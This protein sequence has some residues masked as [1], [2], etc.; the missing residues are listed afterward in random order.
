MQENIF[1]KIRIAEERDFEFLRRNDRHVT[2]EILKKKIADKNI[3]IAEADGEPAG[4]LRYG[5]FWD[6]I[7]FMNMLFVLE[8][9]RGKGVGRGLVKEW[10]RLM[11]ADGHKTL[12]TS[13]QANEYSQHFYRKLGYRDLGGF[14]PFGEEYE[15]IFGK[16]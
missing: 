10:E 11:L 6:E 4:W 1:V 7:P 5:F 16:N 14:T 15:I 13:A 2:E 3:L 9:F 8:K 12:M